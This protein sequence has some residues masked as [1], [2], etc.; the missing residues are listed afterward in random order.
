MM[1][2]FDLDGTLLDSN[3]V[4]IR[5]DEEFL[6]RRGFTPTPE[7]TFTV[8]H[9]IFPVAAQYTKEYCNLSETP[10]EIMAEWRSMAY[11]AYAH[12]VPLKPGARMLLDKLKAQGA[13]M[14]LLT[15]SLPELCWA[16]IARHGLTS[17]F[18]GMFFSQEE[19]L[20]KRD[21]EVYPLAAQRFGVSPGDCVLF[22]DAP[23]NCAAA[24]T[25]GFRVVGVY[26]DFFAQNWD[27]LVQNSHRTVRSLEELL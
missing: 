27:E 11:G 17:Y 5:V 22:E 6:R 14:A 1:Y 9:S 4:W 7:Y 8:S 21:P 3:R 26:D 16:A 15:A 24:R 18:E 23:R 2:F 20:E 25:A 13:R 12:T 19:G 10:E